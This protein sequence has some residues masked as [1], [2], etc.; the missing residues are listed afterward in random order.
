MEEKYYFEI[1]IALL[2]TIA[3]LVVFI[4]LDNLKRQN[5]RNELLEESNK[6]HDVRM[7]VVE[8]TLKEIGKKMDYRERRNMSMHREM[9][10]HIEMVFLK[11]FPDYGPYFKNRKERE[12]RDYNKNQDDDE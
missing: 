8:D 11:V 4:Y 12:L 5:R 1:I 10:D 9:N 3:S 2:V 7:T 6:L